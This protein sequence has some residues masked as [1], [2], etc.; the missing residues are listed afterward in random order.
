MIRVRTFISISLALATSFEVI[1][2]VHCMRSVTAGPAG[3][4]ALEGQS[5]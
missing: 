2:V 3:V 5:A 4:Q 1:T